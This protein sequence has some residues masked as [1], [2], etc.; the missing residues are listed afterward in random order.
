MDFMVMGLPRSRTQW[1]SNFLTNGRECFCYHELLG[2]VSSLDEYRN[3]FELPYAKVGTAETASM[4][5]EKEFTCPKVVIHRDLNVVNE[6]LL[7]T[8]G[9]YEFRPILEK[10]QR[11]LDKVDGIHINFDEIDDNLELIWQTCIGTPMDKLRAE[12][13]Q[14]M[15]I[16]TNSLY[17]SL[18]GA[19]LIS[20]LIV[21]T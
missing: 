14:R 17:P 11:K 10:C 12:N 16:E 2:D 20:Q 18:G 13:L 7:H 1:L 5:I 8:I 15:K 3:K 9:S 4:L 21:E 6:S 19:Q